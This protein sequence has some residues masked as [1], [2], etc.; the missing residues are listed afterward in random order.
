MLRYFK[1]RHLNRKTFIPK[2]PP[3]RR[4]APAGGGG[5]GGGDPIH[6]VVLDARFGGMFSPPSNNS[7]LS[8]PLIEAAPLSPHLAITAERTPF[9]AECFV[10][11]PL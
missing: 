9:R 5:G 8:G 2:G 7:G 6:W 10:I 3:I 11:V 4:V 1:T